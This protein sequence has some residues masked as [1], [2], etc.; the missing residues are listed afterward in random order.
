VHASV[1]PV[2]S[3]HFDLME[4][5]T[6]TPP[7]PS[8]RPANFLDDPSD[9]ETSNL[10]VTPASNP[11]RGNRRSSPPPK[12]ESSYLG[13]AT[14][15]D[16]VSQCQD[17]D[18]TTQVLSIPLPDSY[19][20]LT[21][22]PSTQEAR[23]PY[24]RPPPG[25]RSD[26]SYESEIMTPVAAVAKPVS[27]QTP[28]PGRVVQHAS[29]R[30]SA[31]ID[32]DGTEPSAAVVAAVEATNEAI[33]DIH[34]QTM[35]ALLRNEDHLQAVVTAHAGHISFV[36]DSDCIIPPP[37]TKKRVSMAPPPI[38]VGHSGSLPDDIVRTPYPFLF[39]KVMPKPS[40]L[41][42]SSSLDRESILAVSIRR[43]KRSHKASIRVLRMTIPT[44]SEATT[45][46]PDTSEKHFETL[47]FDDQHFFKELRRTYH[48]LAGPFR[49]FSART[50]Q[51]IDVSHSTTGGDSYV[52]D[53][54]LSRTRALCTHDYPRSPRFL[55]SQGLSN[56]FS[57]EEL[58]KHYNNP[59]IGK[60]RYAWVHWAYRI[61][62]ITFHPHSPAPISSVDS[63]AARPS[64]A[65]YVGRYREDLEGDNECAAGLEFVE[66]WCAWRI[67]L[68]V[69]AVVICALGAALC[70]IFLGSNV[71]LTETGFRD[72]GE[73]VVGGMMIGVFVLLIGWTGV[74]G[75][76][77]VSWIVD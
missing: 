33:K 27:F 75:W 49:L 56:S 17:D 31:V 23:S 39:R 53:T 40:P 57:A 58:M 32:V 20:K 38:D 70:W 64:A 11:N 12:A 35:Q 8:P 22:A 16:Y 41:R 37:P 29:P 47:D 66:G 55:V 9:E 2:Q 74:G 42:T 45:K 62:S 4:D 1:S 50:L 72:A 13:G 51:R 48:S 24:L 69:S 63:P 15:S 43:H 3:I 18:A 76:V 77:G 10:G 60:S 28:G 59:K 65:Q 25:A 54:G 44:N 6:H 34:T 36:P 30:A 52:T 46:N 68:A 5:N 61:S 71:F 26:A 21:S 73:R 19:L 7:D 67:S 14:A